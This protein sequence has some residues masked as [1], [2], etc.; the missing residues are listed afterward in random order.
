[1]LL[2]FKSYKEN[3]K[4]YLSRFP[5]HMVSKGEALSS[6]AIAY[7]QSDALIIVEPSTFTNAKR[8][9]HVI[10]NRKTTYP[11]YNSCRVN[12]LKHNNKRII[13]TFE[14]MNYT[15]SSARVLATL[16]PRRI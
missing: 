6:D 4:R 12:I 15:C 2:G 8:K 14:K 11:V 13:K 3:N 1:M 9:I 7:R 16:S 5:Q 10:K